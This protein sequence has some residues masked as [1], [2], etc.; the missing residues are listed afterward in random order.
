MVEM[1]KLVSELQ[2]QNTTIETQ[3]Q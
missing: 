2:E 1:K 3:I